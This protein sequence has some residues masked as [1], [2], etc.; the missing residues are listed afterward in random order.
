MHRGERTRFKMERVF[1]LMQP[2]CPESHD[3]PGQDDLQQ[4]IQMKSSEIYS[5]LGQ[6]QTCMSHPSANLHNIKPHN[7][8]IAQTQQ[9]SRVMKREK[10]PEKDR[11]PCKLREK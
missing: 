6:M 8:F 4:Y 1:L 5:L 7:H 3:K 10:S 9:L 2:I 11:G